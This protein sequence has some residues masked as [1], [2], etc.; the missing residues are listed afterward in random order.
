MID[1]KYINVGD[2]VVIRGVVTGVVGGKY[3]Y[4]RYITSE[5]RER[6]S[7]IDSVFEVIPKPWEP[8][9][10]D[11]VSLF[12]NPDR[13]YYYRNIIS[14]DKLTLVGIFQGKDDHR[15]WAMVSYKGDIPH[16]VWF[17]DLRQR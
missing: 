17:E 7:Y 4:V 10:G 8:V 15:K 12:E 5:G 13:E 6:S 9:I 14:K 3:A 2:T 16:S 11:P 1:S